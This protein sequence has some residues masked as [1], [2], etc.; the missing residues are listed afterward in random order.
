MPPMPVPST[1]PL[2]QSTRVVAGRRAARG[3]RRA[4]PR[5]RRAPHSGGSSSSR[6]AA[7]RRSCFSTSASTPC[8]TPATLAAEAEL[9][10]LRLA[11]GCPTCPCAARAR[12][13]A[14]PLPFGATTP[15]P[16]TTTRC[17]TCGTP[18]PGERPRAD[19]GTVVALHLDGAAQLAAAEE[20]DRARSVMHALAGPHD[21]AELDLGV[22][23]QGRDT[24]RPRPSRS[25]ARAGRSRAR[26]RP[27]GPSPRSG[28]RPGVIGLPGKWPR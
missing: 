25:R 26:P 9:G 10:E 19:Q 27:P 7:P 22:G 1:A 24:W 20:H 14:T 12:T 18:M 8:G 6:A 13:R 28:A 4:R 23:E 11:R 2:S 15:R 17:L 5:A 16:V 21:A 3:R